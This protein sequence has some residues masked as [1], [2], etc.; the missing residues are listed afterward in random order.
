MTRR[1][2]GRKRRKSK[3]SPNTTPDSELQ[4]AKKSKQLEST[5]ESESKVEPIENTESVNT[6]DQNLNDSQ[7][8][9][10]LSETTEPTCH[11]D[12]D[13][14]TDT[15]TST[16]ISPHQ[17][18]LE[19][20]I[21]DD[22]MFQS[23]AQTQQTQQE[24][25]QLTSTP[26]Y[27]IPQGFTHMSAIPQLP[28]MQPMAIPQPGLSESDV[29]RIASV[30]KQMLTSEIEKLVKERVE[31]ET[32]D[33]KTAINSLQAENLKLI[34]N[35]SKMEVTLATKVDDLEQYSRR[36]CLRIA[37]I[38]EKENEDTSELV[39]EL[40]DRLNIDVRPE[41]IEVSH[42][43][44]PI[45]RRQNANVDGA[46]DLEMMVE[47]QPSKSREIIIRFRNRN[48]RLALL[49]G[50]A[51]LRKKREK[52]YINEDLTQ[53]R[54]ALAFQCRQLKRDNK[55]QKTWVYNGNINITDN[56]GKNVK[57][58][59]ISELVKYGVQIT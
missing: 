20:P 14:S 23:Q 27:Q 45:R 12:T 49:K 57:I 58:S 44:G 24:A 47:S 31:R 7:A 8:I 6:S 30:M 2:T 43:V 46:D 1:S 25:A 54:K 11:S 17:S 9:E 55:I 50:R 3:T 48:A 56:N 41:D 15:E 53:A 5:S 22:S 32:A 21:M 34:D 33:L 39:L 42:R 10:T 35:V 38:E 29:F 59:H 4:A 26:M 28:P 19:P 16:N 13:Q 37:G 40:A 52:T 18:T 51:V 36:S